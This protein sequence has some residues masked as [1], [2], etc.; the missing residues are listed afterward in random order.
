LRLLLLEDWRE[1][2]PWKASA[3]ASGRAVMRVVEAS[4]V[5]RVRVLACIF[6]GIWLGWEGFEVRDDDVT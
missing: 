2:R 1:R 6:G 3:W 5:A 4:R